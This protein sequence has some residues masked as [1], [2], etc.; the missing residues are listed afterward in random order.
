[1][2][3]HDIRA[4][5]YLLPAYTRGFPPG[6]VHVCIADPGV[7][8]E[9]RALVVKADHRWYVGPDNGL[10]H[11]LARRARNLECHEIR[12]RPVPLSASFHGR[13]LFVPVAAQLARGLLPDCVPAVLTPPVP[14]WPEDL[15]QV[16]YIDHFGNAIT[17]L[18]AEYLGRG[19]RLRI[20]ATD[21][22]YARTYSEVRAGQGF[23]YENANGLV[24]IAVNQARASDQLGIAVG[25]SVGV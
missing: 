11:I 5:A 21:L 10:F 4:A 22:A 17:G 2:P 16:L 25:D 24:E 12:W 15:P 6:T 3:S 23:W 20:G 14:D 7:G 1:M 18:R 8:S 19:M 9:R 13:D